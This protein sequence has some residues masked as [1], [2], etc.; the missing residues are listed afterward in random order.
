MMGMCD[1]C[2]SQKPQSLFNVDGCQTDAS[3]I[4]IKASP[5]HT[6]TNHL[7]Q[8]KYEANFHSLE[9]QTGPGQGLSQITLNETESD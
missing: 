3:M 9:D 4:W 6:D 7:F 8:V 5:G 2:V 1:R